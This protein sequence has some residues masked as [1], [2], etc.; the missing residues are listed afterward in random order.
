MNLFPRGD[1]LN[2]SIK[3][4]ISHSFVYATSISEESTLFA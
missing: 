4:V 1:M 3:K 2:D